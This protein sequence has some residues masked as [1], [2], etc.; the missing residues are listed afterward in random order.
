MLQIFGNNMCENYLLDFYN[1]NIID[2]GLKYFSWSISLTEIN[3]YFCSKITD[4]A[5]E[6]ISKLITLFKNVNFNHLKNKTDYFIFYFTI[7]LN[8]MSNFD[9]FLNLPIFKCPTKKEKINPPKNIDNYNPYNV[10]NFTVPIPRNLESQ[11]NNFTVPIPRNLESQSNNFTVPI[12]RNLESQSNNFTVPIP[13]NLESQSNNFTVPIPINLESQSNNFTVPTPK[14]LKSQSNNFTVPTPKNFLFSTSNSLPISTA[15]NLEQDQQEHVDTI[16][17]IW[18]YQNFAID[19]SVMGTGKTHTTSYLQQFYNFK[20]M[21][22]ICPASVKGVWKS[23][24]LKYN[25][26]I[27]II[28]S[29]ESLR[30]VKGC[31]PKHGYLTRTN[32]PDIFETTEKFDELL[33]LGCLVVIDEFTHVKND[34][35]QYFAVKALCNRLCT[36]SEPIDSL[37]KLILLSANPWCSESH[38]INLLQMIG[39]IKSSKLFVNRGPNFQLLGAEE[40]INYCFKINS[41][42][43]NQIIRSMNFNEKNIQEICYN[44][45]LK[46]LHDKI[47]SWMPRPQINA[48]LYSYNAYFNISS[49]GEKKIREGIRLLHSASKYT[50]INDNIEKKNSADWGIITTAN[51]LIQI[52][53][54]EI[55]VRISTYFLTNFQTCKLL[56]YFNFDEPIFQTEKLL[57]KFNPSIINGKILEETRENIY[58]KFQQPNTD[59]RLLILNMIVGSEGINFHDTHGGFPRIILSPSTYF[60]QNMHQLG[61]R[62]YRRGTLSDCY[63]YFIYSKYGGNETSIDNSLVRKSKV[64]K[65]TLISQTDDGIIFPSD[66][67]KL[68]EDDS[69]V[70]DSEFFNYT[71]HQ[72][73]S[74]IIERYNHIEEKPGKNIHQVISR[75]KFLESAQLQYKN[76]KGPSMK[77]KINF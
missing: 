57:K 3:L 72:S 13:R 9:K 59:S 35:D 75:K 21:F 36:Y 61:G 6:Y 34:N 15:V 65:E 2:V 33:K 29:Y 49:E 17:K 31:Q 48:N 52:A 53:K 18:E 54:V 73:N 43:T 51:R 7:F 45:Y 58:F 30:S 56:I 38:I 63:L 41:N 39:I 69:D 42:Y 62:I 76:I 27:I 50:Q 37:S 67:D 71:I 66:Y 44:L 5:V 8:N 26:P 77:A 55:F 60:V 74:D 20:Y 19:I 32:S 68:V 11:S 1:C 16:G 28:I 12:P 10:N 4:V 47:I 64:M 46:I 14:N 24:Q 70:L 25:L 40:L 23:A 22:V